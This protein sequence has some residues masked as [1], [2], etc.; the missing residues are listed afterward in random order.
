[1]SLDAVTQL[2]AT[3]SQSR[4][5]GSVSVKSLTI[6]MRVPSAFALARGV[7]DFQAHPLPASGTR[8]AIGSATRTGEIGRRKAQRAS[9]ARATT[10]LP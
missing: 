10:V 6:L 5:T 9:R 1:M 3:G 2:A 4:V 8:Q 7:A